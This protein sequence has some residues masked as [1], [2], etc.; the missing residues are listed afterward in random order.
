MSDD[1]LE[2]IL[3]SARQLHPGL[4]CSDEYN[5]TLNIN[6]IRKILLKVREQAAQKDRRK[7]IHEHVAKKTRCA[8]KASWGVEKKTASLMILKWLNQMSHGMSY[9]THKT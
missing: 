6:A 4:G 7:S 5:V 1:L 2:S 9:F 8:V 3:T